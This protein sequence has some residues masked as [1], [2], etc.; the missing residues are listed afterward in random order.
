MEDGRACSAPPQEDSSFVESDGDEDIDFFT[1]AQQEA[2][3]EDLPEECADGGRRKSLKHANVFY[4]P[5]P[6]WQQ[7]QQVWSHSARP[8]F[9]QESRFAFGSINTCEPIEANGSHSNVSAPVSPSRAV[10]PAVAKPVSEH[11]LSRPRSITNVLNERMEGMT[12]GPPMFSASAPTDIYFLH[13]G[14]RL[15]QMLRL[16]HLNTRL[17]LTPV[18]GMALEFAKDQHGSRFI[19][20]CL[21]FIALQGEAFYGIGEQI[22]AR[23]VIFEELLP[24]AVSL[25]HD[26]FGNYVVQRFFEFGTDEHR[27]AL[28]EA[29][30]GSVL[31]LCRQVY[32]CRVIQKALEFLPLESQQILTAELRD[33]VLALVM[34][35]NGNHVI[36]RCIDLL[37]IASAAFIVDAFTGHMQQMAQHA[38]GC[39]VIQRIFETSLPN[40]E[41]QYFASKESRRKLV[42]ELQQA[43]VLLT[44]D[45]YGNYVVQ[46]SLEFASPE[47]RRHVI[48]LL[49]PYLVPFSCHKFASN[50]IEKCVIWAC[51]E[52]RQRILDAYLNEGGY[53]VLLRDQYANYVVQKM[54]DVLQGEQ[55]E[56]LVS[57]LKKHVALMRRFNYGKHILARLEKLGGIKQAAS[58]SSRQFTS[59]S[60]R[61]SP[62]RPA[63]KRNASTSRLTTD[64]FP[65]L[66]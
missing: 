56:A 15:L 19:Q 28:G 17:D 29:M 22:R 58:T 48:D 14:S 35:Q 50:V 52:D 38:Y 36:Q 4:H 21:E 43:S 20:Q 11:L 16:S 46:H 2:V 10:R 7:N 60:E 33:D 63:S 23:D 26:V 30:Q 57:E 13:P 1:S 12:L 18:I 3:L 37:P 40:E 8:A 9:R 66:A 34:D 45:Q 65:P 59:Q 24:D 51:K 6:A 54:L 44:Q 5:E 62:K 55:L 41:P 49:L 25:M 31:D 42:R 47:E 27:K 53:E 32:G 39:R 61:T 64:D